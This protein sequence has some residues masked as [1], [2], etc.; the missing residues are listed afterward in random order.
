MALKKIV[1]VFGVLILLFSSTS[2]SSGEINKALVVSGEILHTYG[3]ET[4]VFYTIKN[5]V[6]KTIS[7]YKYEV[8][9][10]VKKAVVENSKSL[11][12]IGLTESNIYA[13]GKYFTWVQD[14]NLYSWYPDLDTPRL[15][16][17][18]PANNIS[19]WDKYIFIPYPSKKNPGIYMVN[20]SEPK[21]KAKLIYP[22]NYNMQWPMNQAWDGYLVYVSSK[23]TDPTSASFDETSD[24]KL[25]DIANDKTIVVDDSVGCQTFPVIQ[26]GYVVYVDYGSAEYPYAGSKIVAYNIKN[27][28]KRVIFDVPQDEKYK[29]IFNPESDLVLLIGSKVQVGGKAVVVDLETGENRLISEKNDKTLLPI[30]PNS[31]SCRGRKMILSW[32]ANTGETH[33]W[34]VGIFNLTMEGFK[35]D[36]P[37]ILNSMSNYAT[38]AKVFDK[39]V[40]WKEYNSGK[41]YSIYIIKQ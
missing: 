39:Y 8:E 37:E 23:L 34:K 1:I 41:D 36:S 30:Y 38:T 22:F 31:Q 40:M 13:N 32:D 12:L 20:V 4:H 2:I 29:P 19:V 24:I 15:I 28:T 11:D 7:F 18:F 33:D 17:N 9:T 10:G 25:Y 27:E 16:A 3:T 35:T 14:N 5:P 26:N 6:T 21:P